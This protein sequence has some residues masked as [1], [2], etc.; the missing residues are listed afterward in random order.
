MSTVTQLAGFNA[1]V[2]I[3]GI[4][5]IAS[6]Y[7]IRETVDEGDVTHFNSGLSNSGRSVQEERLPT[8][9]R[10]E[11]TVE[12]ATLDSSDNPFQAPHTVEA[13]RNIALTL[14]HDK[15]ATLSWV[16]PTFLVLSVDTSADVGMLEPVSFSGKTDG[17]YQRPGD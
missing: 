13:D 11:V 8:K 7:T 3:N 15:P 14:D 4:N 1:A 6:K 2:Q 10:C 9:R 16:F 17:V 5:Y 12:R